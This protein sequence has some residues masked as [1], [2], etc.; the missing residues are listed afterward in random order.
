MRISDWSSDVCSS[1]LNAAVLGPEW[2]KPATLFLG[3]EQNAF[4]D[5]VEQ[6]ERRPRCQ[7]RWNGAQIAHGEREIVAHEI[8]K[9]KAHPKH[10]ANEQ[11]AGP[12]QAKARHCAEQRHEKRGQRT[13]SEEHTSELQSLMR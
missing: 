10:D 3:A 8:G 7:Q 13:R 4:A 9:A 12:R 1:D 11:L 6:Q 5:Q 2:R